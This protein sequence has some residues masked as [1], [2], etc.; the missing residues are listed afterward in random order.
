MRKINFFVIIFISLLGIQFIFIPKTNSV[1]QGINSLE[2]SQLPVTPIRIAIYNEPNITET[3]YAAGGAYTNNYSAVMTFLQSEGHQVTELTQTDIFNHLLLTKDFDIFIMVDNLPRENILNHVKEFW[4]G[5]GS[6]LSFDSAL[7]YLMYEGILIPESLGDHGWGTYFSYQSGNTNNISTRHPIT[8][9]YGVAETFSSAGT[10]MCHILWDMLLGT[11]A[12]ADTIKLSNRDGVNNFATAVARDP[13]D[14]GGKVV[15]LPGL[16]D[17]IGTNM[18]YMISEAVQWL[19][20]KPKGRI[21]FDLSHYPYYGIDLWDL[22][23]SDYAPRYEILRDNLINRSYLLDKLYPS[24]T[25]NLTSSNLAPYNILFIAL[26]NVNYT[27]AEITAVTNWV[28]KG[29]NLLVLGELIGLNE[30]NQRTNDLL[31]SFDLKM[32]TTSSGSGSATYSVTHPT[33][34]GCSQIAVSAPGKIVY[35]GDAFPIWGSDEN[36][37]FV[38]GQE[39]GKGKVVLI[40]DIAPFRDSTIMSSDN[41]QYAINL[42]NWFVGWRS[43]VLLYTDEPYSLDY[44]ITPVANALNEL[45][46]PFYLTFNSYYFN[47]SLNLKEWKLVIIDNPWDMLTS[48]FDDLLNYIKNGGSLIMSSYYAN[49][50]HPL[51]A[52]MGFADAASLPDSV[53]LHIWDDSHAIF[54]TPIEFGMT[55]YTPVT[56]YGT[57]GNLLTVYP[58][59]TALAGLTVS[60]T[61][62]NAI[63]VL[64]N[65]KKTLYNGYLIDQFTSDTDDSTYPDNYEL[66]LNEIAFMWTYA[67]SSKGGIPGY[68]FYIVIGSVFLTLGALSLIMLRKRKKLIIQ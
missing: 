21:L 61:A 12:G 57:E 49:I 33:L 20:P 64:R 24:V 53:P 16:G 23:Y 51:W 52:E 4:L 13:V 60:E 35:E 68:D 67:A 50:Y 47:L 66:W 40:S 1:N 34:A 32:N 22:P 65:D 9:D 25:G 19:C 15:H 18:G 6:L 27:A 38:A 31:I 62:D 42:M 28:N 8:K 7:P 56:D 2:S 43:D 36:N 48:Y 3:S 58:N 17:A 5:G 46:L 10:F 37:I 29:G 30:Y 11:S 45:Q 54:N 39:Y 63:I 41:L 44:D 59:A 26:S 55:Q 14:K